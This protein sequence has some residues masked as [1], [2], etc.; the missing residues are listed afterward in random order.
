MTPEE[1]K[2]DLRAI[3]DGQG[4]HQ[5]ADPKRTA[6]EALKRIEELEQKPLVKK[7]T[8]VTNE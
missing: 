4:L 7:D 1:I 6:E 5:V 2:K 3:A 8:L